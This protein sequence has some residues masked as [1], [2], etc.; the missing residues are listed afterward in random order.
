MSDLIADYVARLAPKAEGTIRGTAKLVVEGEGSVMLD[1]D[2]ACEGDGPADVTLTAT[3]AVL[4]AILSG[5]Q[6]P[7]MAFMSGKLKVD[8]GTQRALKVSAILTG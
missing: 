7:V 2:G 1:A 6:N 8:G 3:D 4:R 5:D